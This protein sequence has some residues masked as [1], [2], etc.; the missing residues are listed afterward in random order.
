MLAIALE[1]EEEVWRG[2]ARVLLDL[3]SLLLVSFLEEA[4]RKAGAGATFAH[5]QGSKHDKGKEI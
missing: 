3:L 5:G 1:E 4:K 2:I